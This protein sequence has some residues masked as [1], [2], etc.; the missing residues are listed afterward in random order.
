MEAGYNEMC[1]VI[2]IGDSGVGKTNIFNRFLN[3]EFLENSKTTIGV[4]FG[5]H[6]YEQGEYKLKVQLWDTAGEERFRSMTTTYY[7]GCKGVLIVF[8]VTNRKSF[9]NVDSWLTLAKNN[10]SAIVSVLLI[11]NKSDLN[12]IRQV[13]TKE[14]EQLA[15]SKDLAYME[16]SAK[17]SRN[18]NEAFDILLGS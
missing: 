7:R 10:S 13:S 3:N 2:L 16:T 4:E 11:G 12:E 8:D 6:I 1:K 17:S 18:I 5:Y 14:A 15:F 9:E